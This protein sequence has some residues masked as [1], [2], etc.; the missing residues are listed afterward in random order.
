MSHLRLSMDERRAEWNSHVRG[1]WVML[2]LWQG[3]RLTTRDIARLTGISIPAAHRM[4]VI[5]CSH[6]PITR[7]G[8]EWQWI[9]REN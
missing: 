9:E 3:S 6:F 7:D 5:L 4:M 2:W 1:G 8:G